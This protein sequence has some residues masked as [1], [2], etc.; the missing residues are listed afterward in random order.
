MPPMLITSSSGC[1]LKIRG[2]ATGRRRPAALQIVA[3]ISSKTR[4]PSALGR[5][6]LAQ[7]LVQLVLA[8]VVVGEFEQRLF[9]L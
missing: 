3:I 5:A 9:A 7:Q 8:E 4:W 2:G 6:V 1:G